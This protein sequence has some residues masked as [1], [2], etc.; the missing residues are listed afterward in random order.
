MFVC[1]GRGIALSVLLIAS[2]AALAEAQEMTEADALRRF[3][4]ENAQARAFSAG[5]RVVRAET[6]AWSL[7]PNPAVTYTRE[8]AAGAQDNFFLVQQSVPLSGRLGL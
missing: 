2:S 6:R 5:I 8:D 4:R 1:T 7:P 3:E